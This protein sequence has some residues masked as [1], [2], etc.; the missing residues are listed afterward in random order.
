MVTQVNRDGL[1]SQDILVLA[2]LQ[3]FLVG[4]DKVDIVEHLGTA[5]ILGGLASVESLV[6]VVHLAFQDIQGNPDIVVF[7]V[8]LVK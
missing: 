8:G 2:V 6:R 1:D 5:D 7:P 4:L 3:V